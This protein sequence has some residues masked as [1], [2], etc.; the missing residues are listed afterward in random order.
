VDTETTAIPQEND[1]AVKGMKNNI[2]QNKNGDIVASMDNYQLTRYLRVTEQNKGK[3]PVLYKENSE[4]CGCTACYAICSKSGNEERINVNGNILITT[5]AI[6]MLPNEE[7]FLYPVVDA[8]VCV[9]CKKC[10]SV[11]AF[12]KDLT[13]Y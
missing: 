12:K 2:Y 6:T 11:C 4:C 7:G 13:A 5:G 9:G 1:R 8:E 3:L 10:I